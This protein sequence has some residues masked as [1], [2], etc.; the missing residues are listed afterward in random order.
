[1]SVPFLKLATKLS[2]CP[3][4]KWIAKQLTDL[5]FYDCPEAAIIVG[6]FFKGLGAAKATADLTGVEPSD[7][8]MAPADD[9]LEAEEVVVAE[10][11]RILLQLFEWHLCQNYKTKVDSF[12]TI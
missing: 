5:V 4:V 7:K 12:R 1:L 11:T 9:L 2:A 3:G 6:D 8:L 10:S